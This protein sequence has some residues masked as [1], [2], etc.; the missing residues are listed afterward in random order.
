MCVSIF[1][2]RLCSFG[3]LIGMSE[4]VMLTILNCG[5]AVGGWSTFGLYEVQNSKE[6]VRRLVDIICLQVPPRPPEETVERLFLFLSFQPRSTAQNRLKP[7]EFQQ[8]RSSKGFFV[9]FQLFASIALC[10]QPFP[11][12]RPSPPSA[13]HL[14]AQM[15]RKINVCLRVCFLKISKKQI[16]PF[17]SLRRYDKMCKNSLNKR[18][19][20]K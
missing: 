4:G 14:R 13:H 1:M 12:S 9:I 6:R 20:T 5:Y 10:C 7:L 2:N 18:R 19:E 15:L 3:L 11:Q 8:L 17:H 16:A